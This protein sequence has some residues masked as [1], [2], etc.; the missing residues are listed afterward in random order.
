MPSNNLFEPKIPYTRALILVVLIIVPVSIYGLYTIS[1]AGKSMQEGIGA[2]FRTIAQSNAHEIATFVH[3]RVVQAG[4]MAITPE[5]Q[6]VVRQANLRY[7]SMS[8]AAFEE[9]IQNIERDW[10]FAPG[11]AWAREIT[12]NS[13]AQ[14]LRNLLKLDS[15]FLR[16]TVTDI[17]GAT[18]AATHKTL[19]Y[20]QADEEFWQGIYAGG[21]GAIS[22][23]DVLHDDVTRSNYIGIGVPI[24]E[25]G[26]DRF[27][28]TLDA[29]I[30]VSLLSQIVE[31]GAL[32][33]T[34]RI[35]LVKDDGTIISAPNINLSMK[36]HSQ[37]FDAIT[38][39]LAT[40]PGRDRGFLVTTFPDGSEHLVAFAD[41][42]LKEDYQNLGWYVLI[43]QDASHAFAPVRMTS[44]LISFIALA[45]LIFVTLLVVVYDLHRKR[46]YVD[47]EEVTGRKVLSDVAG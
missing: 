12:G 32:G 30:D 29:L 27:I 24:L 11:D 4:M 18:V 41:S 5:V 3:D 14:Y 46:A 40:Q 28:G 13:A 23:T 36:M 44:A 20:Y 37:D 35:S 43:A 47:I 15:R 31:R 1:A 22:V 33:P 39:M 25:S 34:S 2:Q 7:P 6:Q 9:R 10:Q 19:D 38:E 21:R 17:K 45:G 26:S 8:Q 42:G 16:I